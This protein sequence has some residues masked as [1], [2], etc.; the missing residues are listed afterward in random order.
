MR[1][2]G[3]APFTLSISRPLIAA[4]AV[5]ALLGVA[6][7]WGWSHYG[8]AVFLEMIASGIAWCL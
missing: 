2:A 3:T 6:G 5:I 4:G 7:I 1:A 8:S